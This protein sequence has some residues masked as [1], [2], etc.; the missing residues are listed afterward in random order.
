MCSWTDDR[1]CP[2]AALA[3]CS[4]LCNDMMGLPDHFGVFKCGS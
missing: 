3:Q 1:E 2:L 4:A